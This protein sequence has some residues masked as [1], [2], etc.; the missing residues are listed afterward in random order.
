M[1]NLYTLLHTLLLAC[2]AFEGFAASINST[3]IHAHMKS[4]SPITVASEGGSI[5]SNN[6]KAQLNDYLTNLIDLD[7]GLDKSNKSSIVPRKKVDFMEDVTDL[8]TNNSTNGSLIKVLTNA[9]QVANT[10]QYLKNNGTV[11]K[12][13]GV[14]NIPKTVHKPLV[15]S[16]EA[17]AQ[18]DEKNNVFIS[19]NEL[20]IK[21]QKLSSNSHPG[22][23]MPIVITI[24]VVPMFAVVGYMALKRGREAWKNRHYKRMDFLLDGMYNE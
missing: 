24:L 16:Y 9:T 20:S 4:K 7:N 2:L 18:T 14:I 15:L 10:T 21:V 11:V 3:L 22:M 6:S 8:S 1:E 5:I 23:V 13:D 19:E 17:L 12:K